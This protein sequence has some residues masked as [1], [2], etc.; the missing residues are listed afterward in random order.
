MS[1]SSSGSGGGLNPQQQAPSH[2]QPWQIEFEYSPKLTQQTYNSIEVELN[3]L[4]SQHGDVYLTD[5]VPIAAGQ[6]STTVFVTWVSG[7][8]EYDTLVRLVKATRQAAGRQA[9]GI[10]CQTNQSMGPAPPHPRFYAAWSPTL[11]AQQEQ[12]ID[13]E[14]VQSEQQYQVVTISRVE[15]SDPNNKTEMKIT[16]DAAAIAYDAVLFMAADAHASNRDPDE[17]WLAAE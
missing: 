10:Y 4:A 12:T 15:F 8:I 1:G 6:Q 17:M 5:I 14:T 3:R 13:N 11:D 7:T 16:W 2:K 9:D